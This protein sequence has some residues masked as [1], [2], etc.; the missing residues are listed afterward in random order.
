[1]WPHTKL[2]QLHVVIYVPIKFI[3]S[4]YQIA[5]N[6]P[7]LRMYAFYLSLAAEAD[8]IPTDK[9]IMKLTEDTAFELVVV[10]IDRPEVGVYRKTAL[11]IMQVFDDGCNNAN[12]YE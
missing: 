2:I 5:A 10:A 1:M 6:M 12:M 11:F 7:N 3:S 4:S 8:E 9:N